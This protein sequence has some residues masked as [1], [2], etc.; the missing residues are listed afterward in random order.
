MAIERTGV[1]GGTEAPQAQSAPGLIEQLSRFEG[2]PQEFLANLL[3]VQCEVG[4]AEG[5]AI[6]RAT[7]R[8]VE[9]IAMYPP[10]PAGGV[11]PPWLS[12][13]ASAIPELTTAGGGVVVKPLL[14]GD[15]MYGQP[16]RQHLLL[17]PLRSAPEARDVFDISAP[18]S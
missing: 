12:R 5:G 18:K 8:G 10:L 16:P 6:L 9:L 14:M 4:P 1:P 7:P 3:R 15:E 13:A 17:V 11:Q 2:P